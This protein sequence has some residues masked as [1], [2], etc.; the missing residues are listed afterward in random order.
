[1]AVRDNPNNYFAWYNDD[2][3]LA[4][5]CKKTTTTTDGSIGLA[6]ESWDGSTVPSGIR[7]H[8]HARYNNVT[9]L[10]DNLKSNAGVDVGLHTAILDYVKSRLAEDEGDLQKA[11]YYQRKY[12]DKIKKFPHRKSG[13]RQI[14]VPRIG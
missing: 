1:M 9:E 7:M 5:V 8:Y 6:Y 4:I 13:T 3:R 10:T 12:T 14:T 11:M 2:D